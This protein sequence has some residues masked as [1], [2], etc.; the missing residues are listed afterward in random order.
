MRHCCSTN[1][2][3]INIILLSVCIP[4]PDSVGPPL[5]KIISPLI[6][7]VDILMSASSF[8]GIKSHILDSSSECYFTFSF[9]V[10]VIDTGHL[11]TVSGDPQSLF[12]CIF[13]FSVVS[14]CRF[15]H[16]TGAA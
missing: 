14:V 9:F 6:S 1:N 3:R 13:E 15:A 4:F 2:T 5:H 16:Q 7:V 10:Q 12:P 8:K 11:V